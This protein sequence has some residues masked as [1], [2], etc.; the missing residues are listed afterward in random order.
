MS[1]KTF[2]KCICMGNVGGP[3]DVSCTGQMFGQLCD[4]WEPE[5]EPTP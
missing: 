4:G 1:A 2:G 5:P 3:D